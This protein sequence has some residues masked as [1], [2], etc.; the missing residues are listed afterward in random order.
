ME[1]PTSGVQGSRKYARPRFGGRILSRRRKRAEEGTMM[2]RER[3]AAPQGGPIPEAWIGQEVMIET[4]EVLSSDLRAGAPVYLEDVNERGIVM[5]VTRHRD[6]NRFSRYFYPVG[7]GGLDTPGRGRRAGGTAA[8]NVLAREWPNL[9]PYSPECVEGVLRTS[10]R[11]ASRRAG[12]WCP[13]P[14]VAKTLPVTC[15]G[16]ARSDGLPV[17]SRQAEA[18]WGCRPPCRP[19][20]ST[21]S[22][23]RSPRADAVGGRGRTGDHQRGH[24]RERGAQD[25]L[26]SFM[27][28]SPPFLC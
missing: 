25:D 20:R 6:Q 1:I 7:R 23:A 17:A 26:L 2:D 27:C 18:P 8:R 9:D 14:F 22:P 12:A 11:P 5:M 13:R 28:G 16:R 24:N 3:P 15:S 19:G 21:R 10:R 4:T